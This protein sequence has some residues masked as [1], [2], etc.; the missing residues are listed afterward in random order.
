MKKR[1]FNLLVLAVV[2]TLTALTSC[3]KNDELSYRVIS[4]GLMHQTIYA[5]QTKSYSLGFV[6]GDTFVWWTSWEIVEPA[7]NSWITSITPE[8]GGPTREC[9]IFINVEP[10]TSGIDREAVILMN[11]MYIKSNEVLIQRIYFRQLATTRDGQL[12]EVSESQ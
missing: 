3:D 2:T 12:Y 10:N 1:V 6:H 11:T 7:D 9:T 8:A 4:E 5:D